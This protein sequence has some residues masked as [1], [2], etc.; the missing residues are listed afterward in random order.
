MRAR[1][2]LTLC[3]A[4]LGLTGGMPALAAD[5]APQARPAVEDPVLE[6]RVLELSHK[7]RCLV[8]QNQSIA[9]SHAP[10][11]VDLRNQ[12]RE[13]FVAGRNEVEIVDYLVARYGDFVL[14]EPPFKT[15][16]LVLW[17]GPLLLLVAGAGWLGLRLRRRAAEAATPLS[18]AEHARA[19]ALLEG[20]ADTPKQEERS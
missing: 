12:V 16:T 15:T 11:A 3:A 9:E 1:R 14:Y 2:A 18:D 13:Q 5:A 8:C 10:L 19:R 6:E 7:L 4:L 17:L 20:G